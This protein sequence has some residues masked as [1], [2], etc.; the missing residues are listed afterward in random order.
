[1][2]ISTELEYA[3]VEQL[4]LDPKNP[5]LG[6]RITGQLLAEDQILALM[7]TWALDELAVSFLQ[8]NF[9]PQEALIVV[10]DH[11]VDQT[12][13]VVAEGNRRLAALKMLSAAYTGDPDTPKWRQIAVNPAPEGLF[14]RVPILRAD[15]RR[16]IETY[17]GYR[18]VT[19]IKEWAPAEKAEYIARLVGG[20]MSYI[21]VMRA[22]GSK[23]PTVRQNYIAFQIFRQLE[24]IQEV[25]IE[26]VE[27]RFSILFLAIREHGVQEFLGIDPLAEPAQALAPVPEGK[28]ENLR[29]F[30]SWVFGDDERD[31]LFTDSRHMGRFAKVLQS[32]DGVKYLKTARKPTLAA[33]MERAGTDHEEVLVRIQKA[34][35][36]IELALST[37]HLYADRD[38]VQTAMRRLMLGIEVMLR[39]FPG[40]RALSVTGEE[41]AAI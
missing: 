12:R 1:M 15:S 10:E 20:G 31:P 5:R 39:S 26:D 24:G 6:R 7:K 22:I 11:E 30:T 25:N 18:H 4:I 36:E 38:E 21:E 33:A 9:W 29:L 16:D 17:L 32:E 13:L 34:T 40:L 19:G 14:E 3:R 23:T 27:K 28:L 41:E 8:N 37:I 35:D 2:P